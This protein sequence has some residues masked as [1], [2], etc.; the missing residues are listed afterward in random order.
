[1]SER[2]RSSAVVGVEGHS[3]HYPRVALVTGAAQRIGKA[4]ALDLADDGW[5]VA[6]H[7]RHSQKAAEEIVDAIRSSGGKA[8]ALQADLSREEETTS[9]VG[10]AVEAI[11]PIGL[12]I[13]NASVFEADDI[14]TATRESW[15][16][17][18][19]PNLRAPFVLTQ[20]FAAARPEDAGGLVVN[21]LDDRVL[22]PTDSYVT[23]S[24]SK[25]GLWS[26][27]RS[28]AIAL[29]PRIRVVGI[30]PGYALPEKSVSD[31]EFRRAV[32]T[33]PLGRSGPPEEICRALRFFIECKSVTGQMVA[34][35]SGLHLIRRS[36]GRDEP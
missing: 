2:F 4:I 20:A 25:A 11:G 31:A 33:L 36:T 30:G 34:L 19:E 21:L 13:N 5:A 29:A 15:D 23:Y 6:V 9:L 3:D 24:L 16:L 35:D 18:M 17:H 1:M 26:L 28:L 22:A 14:V 27:T 7:F 32:E 8:A 10:R 12:L